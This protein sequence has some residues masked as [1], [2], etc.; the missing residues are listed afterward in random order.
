[1][2]DISIC[3]VQQVIDCLVQL[4]SIETQMKESHRPALRCS[5]P[6][7]R[8]VPKQVY[9]PTLARKEKNNNHALIKT[10]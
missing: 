7:L 4:C 1:M 3:N 8:W 9:G 6:V 5:H 2:N 10:D